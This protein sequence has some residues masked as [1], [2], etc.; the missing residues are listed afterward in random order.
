MTNSKVVIGFSGMSCSGHRK[1]S[2]KLV[3][4]FPST[5]LFQTNKYFNISKMNKI[6]YNGNMHLNMEDPTCID[7][8]KLIQ[9]IKQCQAELIFVDS[10]L[11]FYDSELKSMLKLAFI[12][13]FD[14][15]DEE[16][17]TKRR[18]SCFKEEKREYMSYYYHNFVWKSGFQNRSYWDG[19]NSNVPLI[20]FAADDNINKI[21]STCFQE[22]YRLCPKKY[23]HNLPN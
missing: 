19:Q 18:V 1:I 14:P 3:E 22:I 8:D 2:A 12:I 5:V 13:Q 4:S 15:K 16:M 9:D 10:F 20:K 6:P 11:L 7:W 21:I 23:S 17:A